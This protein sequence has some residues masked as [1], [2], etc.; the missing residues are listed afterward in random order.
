MAI[1][2]LALTTPGVVEIVEDAVHYAMHG[3]TFHD[4]GHETHHCCSGA[5]HFCSCHART[6]AAPGPTGVAAV[7]EP[8][9]P[10]AAVEALGRVSGGPSDAHC[11]GLLRPPTA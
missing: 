6:H 10:S 2:L 7:A 3:D 4:E 8:L 5:F 1:A 9:F 11:S